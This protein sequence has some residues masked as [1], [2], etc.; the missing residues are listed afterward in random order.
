MRTK[1]R[2]LTP[3]L[4]AAG[5]CASVMMAP[6]T[7]AAP[8]CTSTG[9]NTT[10]CESRGNAQIVTSPSDNNFY[11]W[12]GWGFGGWGIGFGR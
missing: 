10:Q 9:P 11:P 3:F 5:V 12:S 6:V 7:S 8:D 4:A 2:Y 1:I